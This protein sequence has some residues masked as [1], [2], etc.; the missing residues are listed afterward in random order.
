LFL[1][2]CVNSKHISCGVHRL[3]ALAFIPNP[4]GKPQVNHKDCNKLNNHVDNLEWSTAKENTNHAQLMGRSPIRTKPKK[5]HDPLKRSLPRPVVQFDLHGNVVMTHHSVYAA[6][7]H[8]GTHKGSFRKQL[9][10]SGN[11][12]GFVFK[13]A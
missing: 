8:I 13:Y 9:I 7:K 6:A 3:V 4:D 12:K 5:I 11:H 2:L 10:R 1:A